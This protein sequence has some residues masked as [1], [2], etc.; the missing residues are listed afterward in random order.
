MGVPHNQGAQGRHPP[1]CPLQIGDRLSGVG[2]DVGAFG[3][4]TKVLSAFRRR[5]PGAERRLA[6]FF[7]SIAGGG[8][9]GG[10]SAISGVVPAQAATSGMDSIAKD[11]ASG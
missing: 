4:A 6:Y 7:L 3:I 1:E 10:G 11:V 9:A 8:L 5:S 2:V